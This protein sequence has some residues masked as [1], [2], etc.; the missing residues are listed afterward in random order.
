M[1]L[2]RSSESLVAR[3]E[4]V[5]TTKFRLKQ[6]LERVRANQAVSPDSEQ[7]AKIKEDIAAEV[8]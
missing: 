7:Y 8:K 6:V 1:T 3:I 5:F 4:K 2:F